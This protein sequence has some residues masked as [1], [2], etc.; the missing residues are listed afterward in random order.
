MTTGQT[1]T[2]T[3]VPRKRGKKSPSATLLRVHETFESVA[4]I[5][6]SPPHPPRVDTPEYQQTHQLLIFE[7]DTP[8]HVCAVRHS[9]I[10]DPTINTLGAKAMETHHYP[11]ERSL[12]DAL[13]WRKVHA[14]FPAVYSPASLQ[15]WVDSP[16]NMLVLCDIHHRSTE[17]GIHHLLTQDFAVMPYLKDGYRVVASVKDAAQLLAADE[18]IETADGTEAALVALAQ[19]AVTAAHA[20]LPKPKRT[21]KPRASTPATASAAV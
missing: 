10:A 2:T 18:K 9:T 15:M 11:C 6:L 5:E 21:R 8:C 17:Q 20:V 13:D 16:E 7:K 4:T 12:I 19:A 14:D 1:S 3:A